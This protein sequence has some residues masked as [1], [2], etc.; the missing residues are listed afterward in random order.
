MMAVVSSRHLT[1]IIFNQTD[2][3]NR[4]DWT[5]TVADHMVFTNSVT[6]VAPVTAESDRVS[7][8]PAWG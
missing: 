1:A 3:Y 2:D 7:F 4:G 5:R 6:I 8:R